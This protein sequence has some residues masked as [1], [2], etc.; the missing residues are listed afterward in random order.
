VNSRVETPVSNVNPPEVL[1]RARA[2]IDAR[3][4]R[5]TVQ[6]GATLWRLRGNAMGNSAL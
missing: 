2:G 5:V 4:R 3:S 1:A 6:E